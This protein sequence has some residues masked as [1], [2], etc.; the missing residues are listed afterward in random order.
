MH[1]HAHDFLNWRIKTIQATFFDLFLTINFVLLDNPDND[2]GLR[3][4]LGIGCKLIWLFL[5]NG[6]D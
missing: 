4:F 5:V 2:H 1:E 3:V 6:F